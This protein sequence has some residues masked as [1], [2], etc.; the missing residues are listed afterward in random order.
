MRSRRKLAVLSAAV[1]M[2]SAEFVHAVTAPAAAE[3]TALKG[4]I[5][6]I[7]RSSQTLKVDPA[8]GVD[9]LATVWFDGG[10]LAFFGHRLS[11][12]TMRFGGE[13]T[14]RSGA[15]AADLT[16]LVIDI[17]TGT[18]NATLG[19][20]PLTLGTLNTDTLRLRKEPGA[21]FLFVDIGFGDDERVELTAEGAAALNSALG[22][23]LEPGRP[24]L[25]G[26]VSA[27]VAVD[28][29]LADEVVADQRALT[30]SGVEVFIELDEP[31][32]LSDDLR[33][34]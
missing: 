20:R 34:D 26:V 15:K 23:V 5:L 16:G 24:L 22:T 4:N 12:G 2:C 18:V 13:I 14:V 10:R 11:G 19:G 25:V 27:G 17:G 29:T 32:D 30:E 3:P 9:G 31:I 21:G 7:Q 28:A 6:P 33:R 1:V 8:S